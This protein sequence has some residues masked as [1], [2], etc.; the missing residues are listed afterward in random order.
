LWIRELDAGIEGDGRGCAP[1]S[2][3]AA[4]SGFRFVDQPTEAGD[5]SGELVGDQLT[6]EAKAE[7]FD[8][9]PAQLG[10]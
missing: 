6:G 9:E 2:I 5:L 4:N 10:A 1:P 8:L 3:T 7:G